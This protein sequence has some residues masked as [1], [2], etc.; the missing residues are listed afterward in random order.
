MCLARKGATVLPAT[1]LVDERVMVESEVSCS[2]SLAQLSFE[3]GCPAS[4]M[5]KV[6]SMSSSNARCGLSF[7][8]SLV[9]LPARSV[10]TSMLWR[11]A[12]E[13]VYVDAITGVWGEEDQDGSE[14]GPGRGEMIQKSSG[15]VTKRRKKRML[16]SEAFDHP[17]AATGRRWNL[18]GTV[19]EVTLRLMACY[20]EARLTTNCGAS[21]LMDWG[22]GGV[23]KSR[24][25]MV[26]CRNRCTL[27]YN[28]EGV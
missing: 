4:N 7:V 19:F 17:G 9:S 2:L 27:W 18:G 6:F 13:S 11:S 22:S 28:C 15:F 12:M 1:L 10:G 24:L 3:G 8:V 16:I 20:R 14:A 26:K 23:C 21:P 5:S 25:P